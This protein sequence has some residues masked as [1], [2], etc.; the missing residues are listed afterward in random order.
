MLL[1]EDAK[2]KFLALRCDFR[3]NRL[4]VWRDRRIFEM[5]QHLVRLAQIVHPPEIRRAGSQ[6]FDQGKAPV[7]KSFCDELAQLAEVEDRGARNEACSGA[8]RQPAQIKAR[9]DVAKRDVVLRLPR[10]VVGACCPPV[11]P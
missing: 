10:G 11:W 1:L 4:L 2:G 6:D 9:L 3:F 7:S 5:V 8:Q